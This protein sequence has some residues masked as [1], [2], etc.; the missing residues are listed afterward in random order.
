MLIW[1]LLFVNANS[2]IITGFYFFRIFT[3]VDKILTSLLR[4]FN[5]S[6]TKNLWPPKLQCISQWQSFGYEQIRSLNRGVRQCSVAT[7]PLLTLLSVPS[8]T[9]IVEPVHTHFQI[10]R[11]QRSTGSGG[12][13]EKSVRRFSF[14]AGERERER[15]REFISSK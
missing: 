12:G 5:G 13:R 15:E 11:L 2:R 8:L 9:W 3:K 1:I 7:L 6:K 14:R 4:M 10:T